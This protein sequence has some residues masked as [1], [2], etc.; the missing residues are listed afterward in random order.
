MPQQAARRGAPALGRAEQL[1]EPLLR[2]AVVAA[3]RG[4]DH[5]LRGQRDRVDLAPARLGDVDVEV[6]RRRRR[7]EPRRHREHLELAARA[8]RAAWL[9]SGSCVCRSACVT[10]APPARAARR[11]SPRSRARRPGRRRSPP[12]RLDQPDEHVAAVDRR[13]R[14]TRA[15]PLMRFTIS[16]SA[17]GSSVVEH[18][19]ELAQPAPGVEVQ[20]ALGG[21][22][23]ARVERDDAVGH[24]ECMKNAS[25]IGMLERGPDVV[26]Q[27][28]VLAARRAV[29]RPAAGRGRP[30]AARSSSRT[31]RRCGAR[32]R[33]SRWRWSSGTTPPHRSQI[34]GR[35]AAARSGCSRGRRASA[36]S[37]DTTSVRRRCAIAASRF[38]RPFDGRS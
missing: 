6:E 33:F 10:P 37:P 11:R 25:P 2:L 3:P 18:R 34:S 14:V 12:S 28:E 7:V 4:L 9:G 31:R 19:V 26:R 13:D 35:A 27:L 29:A 1:L 15:A 32:T 24:R 30:S 20:L 22:A 23:G 38:R 36:R 17:S 8:A 21:A 5:H 16:A